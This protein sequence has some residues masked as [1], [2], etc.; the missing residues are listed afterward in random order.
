MQYKLTNL[1]ASCNKLKA[2]GMPRTLQKK[3]VRDVVDAITDIDR[4]SAS[5][6]A[7]K[8]PKTGLQGYMIKFNTI[9]DEIS[10]KT[11][12]PSYVCLGVRA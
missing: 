10:I 3:I 8:S 1:I 6:T 11:D 7:R 12:H 4:S 9:D 2:L 5:Q